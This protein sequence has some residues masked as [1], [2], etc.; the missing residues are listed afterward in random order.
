MDKQSLLKKVQMYLFTAY[1]LQLFLD[2]HPDDK[3]AFAM[4][5]DVVMKSKEAIAEYQDQ[6][7]PLT[8]NATIMFDTYKW[9]EGPWPWE[10]EANM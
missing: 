2:T 4:F 9:I 10:K 7:G 8:A 1:D 6:Y 5:R 3:K